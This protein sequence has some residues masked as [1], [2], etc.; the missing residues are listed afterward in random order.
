MMPEH[1]ART[2]A[3]VGP[4]W[5]TDIAGH[6][7]MMMELYAPILA[8]RP[9]DGVDIV[10]DL[11]Y[12]KHPRQRLDVFRPAGGSAAPVA[13]FFH[14]GA[15]LRGERN[16]NGQIY[17]N[18]GWYL[19]RHGVLAINAGYRL[20]PEVR[21][22]EGAR[23]AGAAVR[24]AA[25]HAASF[26]GDPARIF[27]IGHSAGGAHAATWAFDRSAHGSEG[28]GIAGVILVSA[29]V[30]ADDR[31]DDPNAAAVRAY[32]GDERGLYEARSPVTHAAQ[33]T[34][35]VMIAIAEYENP[36][37]DVYGAELFHRLCAA[38]G[39]CPRFRRLAGHNHLSIICHV[40]TAD[41]ELGQDILDFI[42]RGR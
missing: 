6:V 40:D 16:V 22:P 17:A 34:L 38:R 39:G 36:F 13:I 7:Q 21:W 9:R 24:W 3:R 18:V 20:A 19:A 23:D 11:A 25:M 41:E 35:P 14:G 5:S 33:S 29:R 42:A 27:I 1:V 31:A 26:G 32:F 28:P 12:G 4:V 2:L 10:R 37:L 8:G 30:R 15:F